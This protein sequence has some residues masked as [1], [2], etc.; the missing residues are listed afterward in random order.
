MLQEKIDLEV[1]QYILHHREI[2]APVN[3]TVVR[4]STRGI[5][6]RKMA[7]AQGSK[8]GPG[9]TM[10]VLTKDWSRYLLQRMQFVKRKANTK[11]KLSVE[12][13]AQLKYN[14]LS[15]ISGIVD[16][17]EIPPYLII[18]WDHTALKYVPVGSWT[19]A[20]EG[21]KKVPIAGV[22]DKR[23]ITAVFGVTMDGI[24][25][26]PQL[27]YQGKSPK[28]LPEVRFPGDWDI[29][30]TVNHWSNEETTIQ[31]IQKIILPF[32][33]KQ[34]AEKNL[35]AEQRALCIFDNFKAQLTNNVLQLLTDSSIDVVF[36]PANCT[37]QLQPLDLSVNKPAKDFLKRKFEEW[38]SEQVFI[39]G[40]TAPIKFPL[41]MM[42]PV[43]AQWIKE[44]YKYISEHPEIIQNGFRAAGITDVASN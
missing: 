38:Y 14:Y 42:K 7:E 2:G 4:A 32:I 8:D 25:L 3:G 6:K 18:N 37:D 39:G 1:Q 26:P 29:T 30:Y 23:Q 21:S 44:L 22:D 19:M 43:S 35:P 13:F 11:A 9:P 36:V 34:K 5:L 12:N 40:A 28:C 24:F 33:H 31:Y 15:D 20:K 41:S 10:P 16:M 27:I 17:E